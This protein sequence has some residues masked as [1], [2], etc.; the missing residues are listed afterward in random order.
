[1]GIARKVSCHK[2]EGGIVFHACTV[3]TGSGAVE[4]HA[5]GRG[6]ALITM[7]DATSGMGIARCILW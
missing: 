3:G 4:V 2:V 7:T 1:M 6:G 5:L